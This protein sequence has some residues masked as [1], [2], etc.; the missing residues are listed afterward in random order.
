MIMPFHI[1]PELVSTSI[2]ESRALL[3]GHE[4]ILFDSMHQVHPAFVLPSNAAQFGEKN[5]EIDRILARKAFS[6]G[7]DLNFRLIGE[8]LHHIIADETAI[9][10]NMLIRYWN[11]SIQ[12]NCN[13]QLTANEKWLYKHS[14][15]INHL[16]Y[17]YPCDHILTIR[18]RANGVVVPD[19]IIQYFH[20]SLN[21]FTQ[22][23]YFVCLA[24]CSIIVEGTLKD[25]LI[26]RGY[27]FMNRKLPKYIGGLGAALQTARNVENF[28]APA[29]LPD[30]LDAV[31]KP[32]RN[33]LVHLSGQAFA[34]PLPYLNNH[35]GVANF[36]LGEF[37]KDPLLVH[38]L[39]QSVSIFVEKMYL[40]LRA[41]GHLII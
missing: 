9:D 25:I 33:N 40:D 19:Y 36:T 20:T 12:D 18:D 29:D 35:N 5:R 37:V 31:I 11:F 24:L 13:V 16:H 23:Q 15:T 41:A 3:V 27:Q 1:N 8:I 30:D 21:C 10:V 28:L 2:N 32:I 22:Y 39:L 7:I 4:S 26:T 14:V 38:D 17:N 6:G 34:T